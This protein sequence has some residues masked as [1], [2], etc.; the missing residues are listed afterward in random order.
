MRPEPTLPP[1]KSHVDANR[2]ELWPRAFCSFQDCSWV[3]TYG[4]ENALQEHLHEAHA[5][6]L[7]PIAARMLRGEAPDALLSAYNAAVSEVC[8]K[9]APVAGCSID[10]TALQAFAES[11][12]GNHVEAIVC[13]SCACIHTRVS[14]LPSNKSLIQWRKPLRQ[15]DG[16]FRFLGRAVEEVASLLSLDSFLER[17]DLI[18]V[19]PERRLTDSESFDKWCV[20]LRGASRRKL[21]C[22]PEDCGKF[23]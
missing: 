15:V 19:D 23:G 6:D 14:D 4:N 18:A 22:C 3:D 8:R 17:Y 5:V 2:G 10:R 9:Q 1:G 21:L 12:Q 7:E 16:Q 11:C 20:T 13:F